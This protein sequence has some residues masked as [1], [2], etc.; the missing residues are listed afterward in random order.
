MKIS[1]KTFSII[2][3]VIILMIILVIVKVNSSDSAKRPALIPLVVAG[4]I[5][6][7]E[8][9]K[10]ETLTG[11][12]LPDQQA[13]VFTKVN[14]NIEKIYTDIGSR[15][16]QNQV[17][18]LIDTTLYAQSMKQ[19][20]ANLMQAEANYQNAKLNYERNK[21]LLEQKMV[22]QQDLD[23]AKSTLDVSLAQKQA[24]EALYNNAV[25]QLSYCK[26]TA[27]FA[28]VITKRTYDQGSYVAS[29]TSGSQSS[30]LFTLM[31][32]DRLKMSVNIP[33]RTIP[34]LS[35]IKEIDVKADALPD[36]IF[37]GK[38]SKISQAIDLATRTMAVEVEIINPDGDL[39][40]GM[41]A[42][43]IFITEKKYGAKIVPNQTVLSDD[44]G[45]YI[46]VINA[47]TTVSK[48]YVK[49]GIAMNDKIEIV[50]GAEASDKIVFVGQTLVKDKMKVKITK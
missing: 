3:V 39:K 19:A 16:K 46:Y 42:S 32:T 18:A 50:S 22:A 13:N 15:V 27:P 23:N 5:T 36:K 25:T 17:L 47:D 20:K 9:Q 28:G 8:I 43:V 12:I 44:K 26:I 7:N 24:A 14:G 11:D 45:S 1:K 37:K 2:S 10:T 34:Y 21:K 31:K 33:E 30:V 35:N 6:E 41:F 29:S 38:I 49:T 48:R 4:S 40:P